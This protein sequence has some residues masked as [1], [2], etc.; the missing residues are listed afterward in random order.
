MWAAYA[1]IAHL[2]NMN[3]QHDTVNHSVEFV[4]SADATVHTQGIEGFWSLVKTKFRDMH[5]TYPHLFESYL[6]EC[7]WRRAFP[8]NQFLN[9]L[10]WIRVF[11]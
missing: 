5:G 7:M 6:N 11:Y 1:G 3:Y 9:I 10:Y 8:D 4:S 2:P